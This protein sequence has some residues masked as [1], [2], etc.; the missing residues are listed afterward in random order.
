MQ[1]LPKTERV[2]IVDVDDIIFYTTSLWYDRI[3][4]HPK[5]FVDY[6]NPNKI[7]LPYSY[8]NDFLKIYD[9]DKF[10]FSDYFL[11]EDL[12]EEEKK[13]GNKA[14]MDIYLKDKFYDSPKLL[15]TAVLFY[16][17]KLLQY[18]ELGINR[19]VFVT[20]TFPEHAQAKVDIIRDYYK[21][22][23]NSVDIII[24]EP[25]EK[26]SDAIK[27]YDNIGIIF[28]DELKNILDYLENSNHIQYAMFMIPEYGYNSM[29]NPNN[30]EMI[31]KIIDLADKSH[32]EIHYYKPDFKF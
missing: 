21:D 24:V 19:I 23:M 9:R 32:N 13:A 3:Y 2:A 4:L 16:C 1:P 28:D 6:I 8:E 26:K 11:K 30:S 25:D 27:E 20:R 18:P 7:I 14:I 22:V 31:Q 10:Y 5:N 15:P 17:K 29:S 12:S